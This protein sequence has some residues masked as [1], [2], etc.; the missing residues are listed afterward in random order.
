MANLNLTFDNTNIELTGSQAEEVR[1]LLEKFKEENRAKLNP[2]RE[3]AAGERVYFLGSE[4]TVLF[5][6]YQ[7]DE[8]PSIASKF[9][10]MISNGTASIDK[11]FMIQRQ[12][13]ADLNCLLEKFYYDHRDEYLPDGEY[14]YEIVKNYDA[15]SQKPIFPDRGPWVVDWVNIRSIT[16]SVQFQSQSF[17]QRALDEI[18][19]PFINEHPDFEY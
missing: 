2:F 15:V 17:A 6:E 10:R 16:S 11:D 4:N 1:Q 7:P 12:Y 18:V 9:R 14:D 19:I 5:G 3:P 8:Y 13:R